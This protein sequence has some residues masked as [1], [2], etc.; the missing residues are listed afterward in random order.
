MLLVS[1]APSTFSSWQPALAA[2][3]GGSL[4]YLVQYIV[5]YTP[6]SVLKYASGMR[7]SHQ[8]EMLSSCLVSEE[9]LGLPYT[10][11]SAFF[12]MLTGI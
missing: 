3:H 4:Q 1:L 7:N 2:L 6:H 8:G 11:V 12:E 5:V 9:T 10:K